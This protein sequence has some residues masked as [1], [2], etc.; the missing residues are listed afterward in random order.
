[1]HTSYNVKW[2]SMQ[3]TSIIVIFMYTSSLYVTCDVNGKTRS[4][5]LIQRLSPMKINLGIKDIIAEGDGHLKRSVRS[6]LI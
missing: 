5:I 4:K 2:N 6:A 1:M 3:A